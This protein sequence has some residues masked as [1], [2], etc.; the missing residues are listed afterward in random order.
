MLK[1]SKNFFYTYAAV[2]LLT[3]TFSFLYFLNVEETIHQPLLKRSNVVRNTINCESSLD[4]EE[5]Q[6]CGIDGKN[7]VCQCENGWMNYG[8]GKCNYKQKKQLTAFLL[9]FF[10]GG[11]GVDWFYLCRNNARYIVA[12]VFKLLTL[13]GLG[14]WWLVDWIRILASA[15]SDGNGVDLLSW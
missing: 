14:I 12:G 5:H 10:V 1:L 6:Y 11:L 9:S 3:A 2:L 13:G 4:C 7:F 8:D 15:F